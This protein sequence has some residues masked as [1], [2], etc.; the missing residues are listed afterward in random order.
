MGSG[1]S[2]VVGGGYRIHDGGRNHYRMIILFYSLMRF[3]FVTTVLDVISSG[4][5]GSSSS[6][7][8]GW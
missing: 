7:R 5:T 1:S 3:V 6:H 4:T 2:V 8:L